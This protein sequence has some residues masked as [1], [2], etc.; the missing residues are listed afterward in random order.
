MTTSNLRA[1]RVHD[2][3][4]ELRAR[5]K[6]ANSKRANSKREGALAFASLFV[7]VTAAACGSEE[8]SGLSA[9]ESDVASTKPGDRGEPTTSSGERPTSGTAGEPSSSDSPERA[10]AK[11]LGLSPRF[12]IG[13][14]N[15]AN[16]SDPNAALGLRLEPKID[17]HYMYLSGTGWPSWNSPE[18][19][20]VLDHARAAQARGAVPMF[21]LY[22]AA[23]AG[24]G[25]FGDLGDWEFMER[26]W[27]GVRVLFQRLGEFGAPAIVHLEP[28]VWGS[29]QQASENPSDVFVHVG[30]IVPECGD[31]PKD[32]SGMARCEIRL[33]RN[34][35]PKTL[36]GLSASTFGAYDDDGNSDPVRIGQYLK[37]VGGDE[38]D[39]TVLETLDRDAGCFE[40]GED[41]NC[42]RSGSFYWDENNEHHPNFHDHLAWAKTIR[43]V[44]GKPLLWWQMPLGVPNDWSGWESHY[45]DNRVRYL[46]AHADEFVAAGGFAAVFGPGAERQTTLA[47]DEGQF[48]KAFSGYLTSPASLP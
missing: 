12:S 37:K 14:G 47:T 18:G 42:Q 19:Q 7:L 45:R 27:K 26:Y 25:D 13:T 38:A 24:E 22:Q 44:V 6:R 31:L 1:R 46:F 8:G 28:D 33:A 43:E 32:I 39:I 20:Y 5:S 15:D 35:A 36:V 4:A 9:T 41:S 17:I 11:R 23:S 21:T 3:R 40:A 30:E 29:A 16:G 10:V 34:L 2:P 48:E